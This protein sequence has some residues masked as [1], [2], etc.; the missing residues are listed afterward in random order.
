MIPG[1]AKKHWKEVQLQVGVKVSGVEQLML[2]EVQLQ[3]GVK[4]SGQEP[5]MLV[6]VHHQVGAK[7]NGVGKLRLG[8]NTT[9]G[10][11]RAIG[12]PMKEKMTVLMTREEVE[13]GGEAEEED[14]A[15]RKSV[16]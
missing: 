8:E 2:V 11:A 4:A 10:A 14:G 12:T 6:E 1:T 5:V 13:I 9:L 3:V 16:V 7:A 15:D